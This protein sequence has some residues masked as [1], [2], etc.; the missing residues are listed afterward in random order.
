MGTALRCGYCGEE[1]PAATVLCQYCGS[2]LTDL[3]AP[4][5]AP[6]ANPPEETDVMLLGGIQKTLAG[7]WPTTGRPTPGDLQAR[8]GGRVVPTAIALA[9]LSLALPSLLMLSTHAELL[10]LVAVLLL[11]LVVLTTMQLAL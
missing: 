9:S 4:H 6:A 5:G 8:Q 11:T 2:R 7:V 10:G 3:L 1:Q